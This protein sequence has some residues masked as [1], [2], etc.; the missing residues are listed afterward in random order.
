MP[1]VG[2]FCLGV[3]TEA[4]WVFHILLVV[5]L[6]NL[7]QLIGAVL[8]SAQLPRLSGSLVFRNKTTPQYVQSRSKPFIF[9]L[10][11]YLTIFV[12]LEMDPLSIAT[13]VV[14]L[15]ATCLSTCKKLHDLAGDYGDVPIIIAAICSE[16][17]I[18]GIGLSELQT[19]ILQRDDLAQAWASRTEIWAAFEMALTGCMV[20]FSCLE[21]ETRHLQSKNSGVWAKIK[22]MWNQERFKELLAQLRGQQASITFLLKLLEMDT[23]SSIQKDIRQNARKIQNTAAEAQSLQSRTPSIKMQSQSIF[24]NDTSRLSFFESEILSGIAPSELDFEFDDVVVNSKVYRRELHKAKA[25][26]EK[27]SLPETA[28]EDPD[29]DVVTLRGNN[30]PVEVAQTEMQWL[31]LELSSAAIAGGLQMEIV[32]WLPLNE[33]QKKP[34]VSQSGDISANNL[35]SVKLCCICEGSPEQAAIFHHQQPY[36]LHEDRRYCHL[37]FCQYHT[38]PCCACQFPIMTLSPDPMHNRTYQKFHP[39][40]YG[41]ISNWDISIPLSFEGRQ[42]INSVNNGSFDDHIDI[43]IQ[44]RHDDYL[45][46]IYKVGSRFLSVF[47]NSLNDALHYRYTGKDRKAAFES[48]KIMLDSALRLFILSDMFLAPGCRSRI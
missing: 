20:V 16:S 11:R 35:S 13:A 38:T 31:I 30:P 15:T 22:F 48:W 47:Q 14:G 18:I 27:I 26:N 8:C 24:D 45:E 32:D 3:N 44:K 9:N 21:A 10:C 1:L 6:F 41:I 4:I 28:D 46:G 36:Y 17:T 43:G 5:V 42:Y 7:G 34:A 39:A 25:K 40:C 29:P 33:E 2:R 12:K 19:K 23:L 37:H